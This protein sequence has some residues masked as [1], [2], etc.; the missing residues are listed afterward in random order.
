MYIRNKVIKHCVVFL[1]S[2]FLNRMLCRDKDGCVRIVIVSLA[3]LSLT[4][5]LV[6]V[7][8]PGWYIY[9]G[10][11][12]NYDMK[13]VLASKMFSE[14]IKQMTHQENAG[15]D[16]E[17]ES[18][19]VTDAA[20]H[21]DNNEPTKS[22]DFSSGRKPA[23]GHRQRR[24]HGHQH[25][26]PPIVS[27]PL[28]DKLPAG[29]D[30]TYGDQPDTPRA[31]SGTMSDDLPTEHENDGIPPRPAF[32]DTDGAAG[33]QNSRPES[34][35]TDNLLPPPV[36]QTDHDN[37]NNGKVAS[38]P[39]PPG[40]PGTSNSDE[41]QSNLNHAHNQGDMWHTSDN[42]G[43]HPGMTKDDAPS[44]PSG[45]DTDI[46][47]DNT[48]EKHAD[49]ADIGN[50]DEGGAA[51]M[52]MFRPAIDPKPRPI[53]LLNQTRP[54]RPTRPPI[55]DRTWRPSNRPGIIL[56]SRIP[57]P[58][59]PLPFNRT[60]STSNRPDFILPS[61]IPPNIFPLPF[62]KT[63]RPSN[64]P[65]IILSTRIP[66]IHSKLPPLNISLPKDTIDLTP[67]DSHRPQRP[68]KTSTDSGLQDSLKKSLI[69]DVKE[70]TDWLAGVAERLTGFD[71]KPDW[72][73]RMLKQIKSGDISDSAMHEIERV[74]YS[75]HL[76]LWFGKICEQ[77]SREETC[78]GEQLSIL[79]GKLKTPGKCSQILFAFDSRIPGI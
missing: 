25:P 65:G 78:D 28:S 20:R 56:P 77:S 39:I 23:N 70:N 27:G 44:R 72:L 50:N 24:G 13:M 75:V 35:N 16:S 64:K 74:E 46:K 52:T 37:S 38:R 53:L 11:L 59:F 8:T 9:E 49:N 31:D 26:P 67:V 42:V 5:G 71:M 63:R 73:L 33:P 41:A 21:M 22:T 45:M 15:F 7:I 14:N 19:Q 29:K 34:S 2:L 62:N 1:R 17:S 66:P 76:G 51:N 60:Q 79:F 10:K 32:T 61:R 47:D 69:N 40:R 36:G 4:V 18:M 12:V 55:P 3:V 57:P 58:K 54:T 68:T 6:A 30:T 43:Q 48:D